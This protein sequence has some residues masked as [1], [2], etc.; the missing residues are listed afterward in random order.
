[1]EK[2]NL[3]GKKRRGECTSL[4]A[5]GGSVTNDTINKSTDSGAE[6]ASNS[7][8][9]LIH[10]PALTRGVPSTGGQSLG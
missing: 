10:L 8:G 9:F 5:A 1:M 2:A 7:N 6:T 3:R 4:V